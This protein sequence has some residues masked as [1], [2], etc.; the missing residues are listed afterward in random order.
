MLPA[1]CTACPCA[2]LASLGA[3]LKSLGYDVDFSKVSCTL[4][5]LAAL[6]AVESH[7]ACDRE[8]RAMRGV[9]GAARAV[10]G[11]L[12]DRQGKGEPLPCCDCRLGAGSSASRSQAFLFS[13]A[14]LPPAR[15]PQVSSADASAALALC[16]DTLLGALTSHGVSLDSILELTQCPDVASFSLSQCPAPK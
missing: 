2:L 11:R 9:A 12:M 4:A 8:A 3:T 6:F 13:G 15:P 10:R 1:K 7:C 14:K 5:S 16:Q